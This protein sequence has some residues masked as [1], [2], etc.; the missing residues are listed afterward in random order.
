MTRS[1]SLIAFLL[2]AAL[3][4]LIVSPF[5]FLGNA[6]GHDFE[7]HTA[8]WLDVASQWK[9]GLLYPRWSQWANWGYGEPRFIFYPPASWLLGAALGL[10]LPW[11]AVPGAFIWLAVVLSGMN[12]FFFARRWLSWRTA[13]LAAILFAANPYTLLVVYIRSDFAE[14]LATSFLPLLL[15]YLLRAALPGR[16]GNFESVPTERVVASLAMVFAAIWLCNAPAGVM[17]TY[18]LCILIATLAIASRTVRPIVAGASAMALGLALA[19]F[20]IVPAA[21][22]QRWVNISRAFS[23]GFRPEENFLFTLT[24]NP[25]HN[26]FNLGVS[27][28]A[29]DMLALSAIAAVALARAQKTR[30]ERRPA[31]DWPLRVWIAV[32]A[33]LLLP[34]TTLIWRWLPQLRFLQFPWRWLGPLGV[35]FA[36]FLAAAI[37]RARQR[38]MLQAMACA[39]LLGTGIFISY[40]AWWASDELQQVIEAISSGQGFEGTDEYDPLGDDRYDLPKLAPQVALVTEQ[41]ERS[42]DQPFAIA[43]PEIAQNAVPRSSASCCA[44][45]RWTPEEKA[46]QVD[47]A[48]P[49]Q[50]ALRL[51]KYPAWR[52]EVNEHVVQPSS[53]KGIAQMRIPIPAGPSRVRVR[54]IRTADRTVGATLTLMAIAILLFLCFRGKK[55]KSP[56]SGGSA[57]SHSITLVHALINLPAFSAC[58][59]SGDAHPAQPRCR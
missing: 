53:P 4:T 48:V 9:Q 18:S 37:G 44:I 14:L 5:F 17:A 30:Q 46:V 19:G 10:I 28:I 7:F 26:S 23:F 32:I 13:I 33:I 2:I 40:S 56:A 11:K 54:F 34:V 38:R 51:L 31:V 39:A 22:E 12:M 24:N 58:P 42:D 27:A 55:K 1:E 21:F 41:S 20:F 52:V 45:E 50:I 29:V 57:Q 16:A 35:P 49:A 6:S 15:L 8:S 59:P 47:S 36:Y 43:K 3:A 25:D